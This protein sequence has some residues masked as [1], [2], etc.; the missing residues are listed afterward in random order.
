[1][2][3]G[4]RGPLALRYRAGGPSD[5]PRS[6]PIGAS[7]THR[8]PPSTAEDVAYVSVGLGVIAFQRLQVRRNELGKALSDHAGEAGGPLE[9]VGTLVAE[10]LKLIEERVGAAFER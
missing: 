5:R 6:A 3:E 7:I 8:R 4:S 9:L 1:M 10:R 2:S